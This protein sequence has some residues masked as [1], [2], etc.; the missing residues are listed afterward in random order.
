MNS[1]ITSVIIAI[2]YLAFKLIE[3][4]FMIKKD[5]PLKLI[6]RDTLVV[7]ISGLAGFFIFNQLVPITDNIKSTPN[8]FVSDPDF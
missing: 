5:T 6:L 3:T 8:V 4:K 2:C 7:Y 1:N